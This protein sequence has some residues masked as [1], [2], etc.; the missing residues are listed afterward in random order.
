MKITTKYISDYE[1]EAS[2]E[3]GQK[4]KIDM[5][6]SGKTDQSPMQLVLSALTGCI[7]VEIALV[8]KK[9]RKTL[10][11]LI[12]EAEGTR[13]EEAPKYFTNIHLLFTLVSPDANN[14][15]LYKATKLSLEKYCSVASS[16][17][18]DIT[19]DTKVIEQP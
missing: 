13:R 2:T 9:R 16:L 8:I 15:E 3:E 10:I 7:A 5:K 6:D 1:Y 17:N 11:D 12:I 14:E 18:A 4:V 19:F